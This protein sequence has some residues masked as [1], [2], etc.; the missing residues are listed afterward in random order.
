MSLALTHQLD[1]VELENDE[2][3]TRKEVLVAVSNG[4]GSRTREKVLPL[5][6]SYLPPLYV[7]K[8]DKIGDCICPDCEVIRT[9]RC[10][11]C[12]LCNKCV[13]RFDHHCPWVHNCIGR[14]N[15]KYFYAFVAVQA[16]YLI[17]ITLLGIFA[18]FLEITRNIS[19]LSEEGLDLKTGRTAGESL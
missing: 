8:L 2:E 5:S 9:P 18:I 1:A 14:N 12:N 11:H 13:D 17:S 6:A 19:G 10:R 7:S 15:Y 4:R 16:A 3:E